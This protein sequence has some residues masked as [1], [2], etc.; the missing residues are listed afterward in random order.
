MRNS[1]RYIIIAFIISLLSI[2]VSAQRKRNVSPAFT[3]EQTAFSHIAQQYADSLTALR[4]KFDSL[5]AATD[6]N[7]NESLL[8]NP[9]YYRLFVNPM[10]Y[11][12][13]LKQT[14]DIRLADDSNTGALASSSNLKLNSS[15]ND[16]FLNLYTQHPNM[17]R[18]TDADLE[19]EGGVR[20]DIN[21]KLDYKATVSQQLLD[22]ATVVVRYVDENGHTAMEHITSTTWAKSVIIALPGK[23]GLNI[24]PTM[25][26]GVSEGEY[27]LEAK[28]EMTYNWL[29][30]NQ[31]IWT[32][33][34]V[35]TPT[36]EG[37]FYAG[38]L[39]AYLNAIG[40]KCQVARSFTADYIVNNAT[41][42]IGTNGD[43]ST[44]NT[45]ISNEG[46]TEEN[47]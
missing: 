31:V 37:V 10:L 16:F 32:G 1:P 33:H 41:I 47:R 24:V 23:A 2:A 35:S 6:V 3:P 27:S 34:T 38:S 11:R 36:M 7:S 15:I 22:V 12:S 43:D 40:S 25:K 9:Y 21:K 18:L 17:V 8:I 30:N 44:Q 29:E 46:A 19:K 5:T 39:G 20:T 45:G 4:I 13:S 28:G 42:N 14:M 26:S